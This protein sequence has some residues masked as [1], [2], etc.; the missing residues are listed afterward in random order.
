MSYYILNINRNHESEVD[1]WIGKKNIAPIFYGNSTLD[2]IK[3]NSEPKLPLQAYLDAKRFVDTFSP[4]INENDIIFSIGN[5]YVYFYKQGGELR[6]IEQNG[7][8]LVK[9]FKIRLIKKFKISECPLVLVTIKS[10]RYISAGTFRKIE[11][12][13]YNG[14]INAIDYLLQKRQIEVKSFDLYLQCL[15]SLEFE[16]LIA[17]YLEEFGLFVPAYK[18]GYVKN[19]D[20]FCRNISQETISINNKNVSP[21]SSISIQVKLKINKNVIRDYLDLYFCIWSDI[22]NENIIDWT[23]L[24]QSIKNMPETKKWLKQTLF[25][26]SFCNNG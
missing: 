11:G 6:E 1:D 15:S 9:G 2:S 3:N 19:Y 5:Q 4:S 26:V 14:N 25:W 22:E 18:G 20:L 16:T 8:D 24:H 21:N 23:K 10:N 7:S 17:K 13:E 12:E